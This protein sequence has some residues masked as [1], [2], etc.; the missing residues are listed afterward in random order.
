MYFHVVEDV[1][2]VG[3]VVLVAD[4]AGVLGLPLFV[5]VA[6]HREPGGTVVLLVLNLHGYF[7]ILG[8]GG[9]VVLLVLNLHGYINILEPGGIVVLLVLNLDT[10]IYIYTIVYIFAKIRKKIH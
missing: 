2:G 7:N 4:D 5:H 6:T 9:T 8:P 1:V 3:G 10:G